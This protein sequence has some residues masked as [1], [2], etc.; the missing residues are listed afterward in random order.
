MI[1][2]TS[3]SAGENW[4]SFE[5]EYGNLSVEEPPNPTPSKYCHL[6]ASPL[7]CHQNVQIMLDINLIIGLRINQ[8]K[9][10]L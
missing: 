4:Q 9:L 3:S 2:E 5:D 10:S 8:R 6:E 1:A 7:H